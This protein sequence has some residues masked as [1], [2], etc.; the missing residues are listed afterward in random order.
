[1][2]FLRQKSPAVRPFTTTLRLWTC[3]RKWRFAPFE[4]KRFRTPAQWEFFLL[5][6][7]SHAFLCEA[8]PGRSHPGKC[9]G[10]GM[11]DVS[12]HQRN[13]RK[14]ALF[15][16]LQVNTFILPK[17]VASLKPA[18]AS[19][20]PHFD[21]CLARHLQAPGADRALL[22]AERHHRRRRTVPKSNF[23]ELT[24]EFEL[25]SEPI[26]F[27]SS[28]SSSKIMLAIFQFSNFF[29]GCSMDPPR[30]LSNRNAARRRRWNN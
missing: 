2:K 17:D 29:P 10:S 1:M 27:I 5:A 14:Q 19:V 28:S 15:R 21:F 6:E 25:G 22:R 3:A 24:G 23:F 16:T 4:S 30:K 9:G 7:K 20:F 8:F 18:F 11:G 12:K 13:E 26:V